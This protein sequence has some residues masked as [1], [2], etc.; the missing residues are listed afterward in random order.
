MS[1]I[2]NTLQINRLCAPLPFHP[3]PSKSSEL[4]SNSS[5]TVPAQ[6]KRSGFCLSSFPRARFPCSTTDR[7]G[8]PRG[9]PAISWGVTSRAFGS[10]GSLSVQVN[11]FVESLSQGSHLKGSCWKASNIIQWFKEQSEPGLLSF[12]KMNDLRDIN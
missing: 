12:M 2:K 3:L 8:K 5:R 10:Q 4:H 9:K 1:T 11:R 6:Q 7:R